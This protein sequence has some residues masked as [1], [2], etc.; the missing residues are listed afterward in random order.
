MSPGFD[1]HEEHQAEAFDELPTY[2]GGT[3]RKSTKDERPGRPNHGS[4][5]KQDFPSHLNNERG[6]SKNKQDTNVTVNNMYILPLSINIQN[7]EVNYNYKSKKHTTLNFLLLFLVA[8]KLVS[9]C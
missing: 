7:S 3:S 4:R 5:H 6:N 2:H 8:Q 9:I 1:G